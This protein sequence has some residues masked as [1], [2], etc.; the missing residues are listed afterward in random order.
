MCCYSPS[1]RRLLWTCLVLPA[2]STP[3]ISPTPL[4][5]DL[6]G[7]KPVYSRELPDRA[8]TEPFRFL[9]AGHLYGDSKKAVSP[10]AT[11]VAARQS[12]ASADVD[13]MVCCGD[14]FRLS[15]Q[16]AFDQVTAQLAALPFPVFNAVGNHDVANRSAY[17]AR[18]GATYGAFVH[19]G[20]AFVLLDTELQPWEIAGGQLAFLLL[21]KARQ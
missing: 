20:C 4:L 1:M 13:L 19:G 8:A 18:F 16:A 9:I 3:D 17:E 6:S 11:F 15:T 7:P 2:C 5:P 12:L 10:A 14:T 21:A